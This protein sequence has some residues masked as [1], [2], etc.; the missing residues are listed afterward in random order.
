MKKFLSVWMALAVAVALSGC[1]D[2][3][4]EAAPE[5]TPEPEPTPVEI[6]QPVTVRGTLNFADISA[7]WAE[8]DRLG[9]YCDEVVSGEET[10]VANLALTL[11]EGAG[12]TT[13][14]FANSL[15]MGADTMHLFY[16]YY[17]YNE[18]A[19]D[20]STAVAGRIA[21]EQSASDSVWV[22]STFV[23]SA[24]VL[25]TK[26]VVAGESEGEPEIEVIDPAVVSFEMTNLFAVLDFTIGTDGFG[27]GE[28]VS[29]LTVRGGEGAVLCGAFT[30]DLTASPVVPVFDENEA[31]D[32]VVIRFDGAQVAEGEMIRAGIVINPGDYTGKELSV[33]LKVGEYTLE[34]TFEGGNYEA[35]GVYPVR[36][37]IT[38]QF[39]TN[40]NENGVYANSYIVTEPGTKYKFDA[41]VQGNGQATTGI[42]PVTIDPKYAFVVWESSD[43]LGGVIADV[44]LG[45]DGFVTFTTSDSI[46]GNA[47]IAVTD[48]I[49]TEDFPLGT[50]LWSWHIWSTDYSADSDVKCL[51]ADGEAFMF[52]DRNLGALSTVPQSTDSYGLKYQ[53]GR[54]DP[55]YYNGILSNG[56]VTTGVVTDDEHY[57]WMKG[58]YYPDGEDESI[59][60]TIMYPTVF[61]SGSWASGYDWYYGTGA[62][63]ADRNNDLWGNP[64]GTTGVKTIYDPCPAGYMVAPQTAFTGFAK[65]GDYTD[66]WYFPTEDG[67]I[68]FPACGYLN[69]SS[70]V[71]VAGDRFGHYGFYWTSAPKENM[72]QA[73]SFKIE[74]M[75][76]NASQVAQRAC[77][78]AVRCVREQR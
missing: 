40:L 57:G 26:S 31:A 11:E 58:S 6:V 16:G 51:N 72:Y 18:A 15:K 5:P 35:D 66:G 73:L 45:E 3:D 49:E 22:R 62:S 30:A 36:L 71:I 60:Y 38:D 78:N 61:F 69:Y 34:Y 50:I 68:Y 29:E 56:S 9:L 63:A 65:S 59:A 53:W 54:K 7:V 76:I 41:R 28:T 48:G 67:R 25:P 1:K 39:T 20:A 77:G 46:G 74:S 52:M 21:A 43:E 12:T 4:P 55:F 10:G 14:T 8:G 13:A 33:S 37:D 2:D 42:V 24:S 47:L 75:A 17:P 44:A 23:G 70:G 19:G 32:S 64:D 27:I